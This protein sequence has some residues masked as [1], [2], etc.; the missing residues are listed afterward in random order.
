MPTPSISVPEKV[1]PNDVDLVLSP[2]DI[3]VRLRSKTEFMDVSGGVVSTVHENNAGDGSLFV[4]L[5][6][7]ITLNV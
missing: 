1:K 7:D 5:S 6:I 3:E 2:L 4:E